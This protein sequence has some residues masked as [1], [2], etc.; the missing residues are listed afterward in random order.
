MSKLVPHVARVV[1]NLKTHKHVV[2]IGLIVLITASLMQD[3]G[4]PADF[5]FVALSFLCEVD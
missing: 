5:L 3:G 2:H 4:K 1:T